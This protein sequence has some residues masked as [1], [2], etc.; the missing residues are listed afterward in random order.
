MFNDSRNPTHLIELMHSMCNESSRKQDE[1]KA[2]HLEE[3]AQIQADCGGEERPAKK[4][5]GAEAKDGA[6]Q[7]LNDVGHQLALVASEER[8]R[9]EERQLNAFT[10]DRNKS[11]PEPGTFACRSGGFIH[12]CFQFAFEE[13]CL[14]AHPEDHPGQNTSR[15]EHRN[16]FKNLF[17][18]LL[19]RH[20]ET[21]EQHCSQDADADRAQCAQPYGEGEIIILTA[22]LL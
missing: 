11:E 15:N 19:K 14:F 20:A 10:Y 6:S 13:T 22:V 7:R 16:A 8:S 5:G 3:A 2:C 21:G 1:Q 9:D 17:G 12:T 18:A 4:G